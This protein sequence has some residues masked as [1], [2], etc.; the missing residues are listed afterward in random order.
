MSE[1]QATNTTTETERYIVDGTNVRDT[2][3]GRIAKFEHTGVAQIGADW[4]NGPDATPE[5][6]IWTEPEDEKEPC[7]YPWCEAEHDILDT[8]CGG[9]DLHNKVF[10]RA[11]IRF[12]FVLDERPDA[13]ARTYINWTDCFEAEF[14]PDQLGRINDIA[15]ALIVGKAAFEQFVQEV[16]E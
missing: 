14:T 2:M 12:D 3:T 9:S 10:E 7:P 5:D 15:A 11:G 13:P 6:Y 8:G 4:L 1:I 16:T